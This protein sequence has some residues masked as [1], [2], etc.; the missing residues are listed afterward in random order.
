[1][2]TAHRFSGACYPSD[3]H[4]RKQK[5]GRRKRLKVNVAIKK[6]EKKKKLESA[7]KG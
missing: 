7:S 1:V 3:A 4:N 5:P 2:Q 6:K